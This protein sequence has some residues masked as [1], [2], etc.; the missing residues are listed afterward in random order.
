MPASK[1]R[2]RTQA[3]AN[4][5]VEETEKKNGAGSAKESEGMDIDH[6]LEKRLETTIEDTQEVSCGLPR[7][8]FENC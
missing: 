7:L 2:R 5:T 3:T 4:K 1:G 6:D 8:S